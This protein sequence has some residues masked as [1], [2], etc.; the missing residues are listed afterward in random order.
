MYPQG[1]AQMPHLQKSAM[2]RNFFL[3][4]WVNSLHTQPAESFAFNLFHQ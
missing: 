4:P 1:E 3:D 2:I